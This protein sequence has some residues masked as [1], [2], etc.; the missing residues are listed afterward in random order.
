MKI[1]TRA[2]TIAATMM[3]AKTAPTAAPAGA[4]HK[5]TVIKKEIQIIIINYFENTFSYMD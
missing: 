2:I 3:M 5:R 1:N 4:V